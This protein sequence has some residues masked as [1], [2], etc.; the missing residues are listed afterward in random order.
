MTKEQYIELLKKKLKK[1]PQVEFDKAIEYFEEYFDDAG[2]ENVAQAIEDLG[3]PQ[4]AADQIIRDFAGDY[5]RS[6][7]AKKDVRKGLSGVWIVI[8]AIFASPIALPLVIATVA[9][10]FT[11]ML[12]VLVVLLSIGIVG[13][14]LIITAPVALIGAFSTMASSFPVA[15]VC[16]GFALTAV[17]SGIML[18]YCSYLLIRRFLY[19]IV[20]TFGRK[21][22]KRGES[23]EN[24]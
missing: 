6:T 17:G 8:L 19:W 21:F 18:T 9:V 20:V 24:E 11:F 16:L 10:L 5:S 12:C 15:L 1:L 13:A 23:D 3:T 22:A 7:E 14:S 4:M 2:E